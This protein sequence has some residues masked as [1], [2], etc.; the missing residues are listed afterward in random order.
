MRQP[1]GPRFPRG[2][3]GPSRAARTL[4]RRAAHGAHRHRRRPTRADIIERLHLQSAQVFISSF[5]RPNIRYA[6]VEKDNARRQLLRFIRDEHEG[7]AGIVYRQAARRSRETAAW[8]NE[9]GIPPC[10]P[11][12]AGPPARR[13]QD[14]FL[15][16]DGLVMVATIAFGM[17]IDKP[18]VRF[19]AH[20]DPPKNI[21]AITRRPAVPAA[22]ANPADLDG[23]AWLT[24][25][26]S[27]A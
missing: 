10:L 3:S 12:R 15:R 27:A 7:D 21:E 24:W 9:E 17:G 20:L 14:R 13:H 23:L 18:D 22:T 6:I 4:C 8:L 25:S 1:V 5:D 19:V 2:L 16:E 11:R 26:T